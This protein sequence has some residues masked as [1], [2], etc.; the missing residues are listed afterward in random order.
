MEQEEKINNGYIEEKK[1][2]IA[3]R[4]SIIKQLVRLKERY[5]FPNV[6]D[7]LNKRIY[8]KEYYLLKI[9][10]AIRLYSFNPI[11][12][13]GF[14]DLYNDSTSN[15]HFLI[16]FHGKKNV[17]GELSFGNSLYDDNIYCCIDEKYRNNGLG[18]QS[19][20]LFLQYLNSKGIDHVTLHVAKTN[21]PSLRTVEKIKDVYQSFSISENE[22]SMTFHFCID[23]ERLKSNS[24]TRQS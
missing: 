4:E 3:E 19:T 13:N 20:C 17:I 22:N 6:D 11:Y 16:C 7:E 9:E 12:T 23:N 24:T 18:F 21:L 14:I 10:Q 1:Q 15:N 2:L 5:K 8:R